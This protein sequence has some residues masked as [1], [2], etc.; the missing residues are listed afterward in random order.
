MNSSRS[1]QVVP[2]GSLIDGIS[3]SYIHKAF[4]LHPSIASPNL[5]ST[6]LLPLVV[7]D[8][9]ALLFGIPSHVISDLLTLTLSS[10]SI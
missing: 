5:I 6:L 1:E 7:F 8:M 9:L 3:F 4:A 2:I 10:N